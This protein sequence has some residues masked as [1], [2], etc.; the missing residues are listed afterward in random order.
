MKS[1]AFWLSALTLAIL[2]SFAFQCNEDREY[3]EPLNENFTTLIYTLTP[4][5]G[6]PQAVLTWRDMDGEGGEPPVIVGGNLSA[7]TT[8]NGSITLLDE[9]QT[10]AKNL[11]PLIRLNERG[12]RL[13]FFQDGLNGLRV[14]NTTTDANGYRNQ[15]ITS[16]A[17]SGKLTVVVGYIPRKTDQILSPIDVSSAGGNIEMTAAF[18]IYV[19]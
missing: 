15:L 5:N 4:Q 3:Y 9:T 19:E 10:P 11:T 14:M 17:T 13:F 2:L 6:G 7:Y 18:N 1:P 8:Y 16:G 12:H